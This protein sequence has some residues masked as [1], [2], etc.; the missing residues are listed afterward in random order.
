SPRATARRM[1]P[2]GIT[3]HDIS[4]IVL[5][6]LDSDHFYSGWLKPIEKF[7][8]TVHA[9]HRHRGA[10]YA[11]GIPVRRTRLFRECVDIDGPSG[12]ESVLLAHDELGSAG[13]VIEHDGRR[14][15]FATD[16]GRATKTLFERFINLHA[17]AIESNYD[18]Q[19]QLQSGRPAMLVRRIMSG[20][21]HLSNDQAMEAIEHIAARSH[22]SHIVLLHLSR[23]CNCPKLLRKFYSQYA[24]HL[25][26]R[27]T[28]SNQLEPTPLLEV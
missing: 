14:L 22:L 9:H 15:G 27:L 21:G 8:I 24:P 19:M 23:E 16:V 12:F 1:A 5:T 18:R 3:L 2:L 11:A 17:L 20:F 7:G 26:E 13:F 28:L 10:T 6:H 25:L 4:A